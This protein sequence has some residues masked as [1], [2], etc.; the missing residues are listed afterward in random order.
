MNFAKSNAP[1]A[2]TSRDPRLQ[3]TPD[4]GVDYGTLGPGSDAAPL[5]PTS[6][7]KS[8]AACGSDNRARRLQM[9][10]ILAGAGMAIMVSAA[11]SSRAF[12][13]K[14]GHTFSA[15]KDS[16]SSPRFTPDS[17]L[18]GQP[19]KQ[20]EALLEQAVSRSDGANQQIAQR[21]NRWRGKLKWDSQLRGLTAAALNSSDLNV[22]VSGVEVQL[23]AYGLTKDQSSA[24]RLIQEA[25][26]PDHATKIWA[27][28]TLGLIGNRG[29]ETER[30][31]QVLVDHLKDS[32]VDSRRWAVEGLALVGTSE[33]IAPLLQV[34]H[35]DGSPIVRERAACSVAESGIFTHE[36]RM[37]AVPTLIQYSDDSSLD[38]QTHA[39]AFEALHDITG[40]R[41]AND[42]SA[43]RAWYAESG[44]SGQ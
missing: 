20:A 19:Q 26:S 24:D 2:E 37:S 17:N 9:I 6:S 22:R 10:A 21:V 1:G 43:W 8:S 13:A 12:W 32:D 34:M 16:E 40:Q 35:D 31:V 39:W 38:A 23:A 4:Y 25:D 36:Q 3:P 7:E 28:W 11:G 18:D 14:V 33:T 5:Y 27:L 15:R 30:V 42:S 29:V 44:S 41:L